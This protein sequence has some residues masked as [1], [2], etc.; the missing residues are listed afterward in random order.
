MAFTNGDGG[1]VVH[2]C[3]K[4]FFFCERKNYIGRHAYQ[5]PKTKAISITACFKKEKEKIFRFDRQPIGQ[6][7]ELGVYLAATTAAANGI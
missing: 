7:K 6:S 4:L 5:N 2:S 3:P 1:G